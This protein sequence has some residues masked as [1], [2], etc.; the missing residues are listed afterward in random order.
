[1]FAVAV[2]AAHADAADASAAALDRLTKEFPA[3]PLTPAALLQLAELAESRQ[4]W[5]AAAARFT[6][7]AA[8]SEGTDNQAFALRGLAWAHLKQRDFGPAAE[9]FGRIV[10]QFPNHKLASECMYY[11]AESLRE[12]GKLE[13]AVAAYGDVLQRF[14]PLK[15]AA[16]GAEQNPPL[17]YAWLAG[18]QRARTLQQM[19]DVDQADAAYAALL[20]K[21]PRPVELDRILDEWALLNYQAENYAKAD[22][23]FRRLLREV[24][25][26]PLADNARLSLAESDLVSGKLDDAKAAFEGLLASDSSD[27]EVKERSLYQLIVLG[28]DRKRW[29]DVR[30]LA[31]RLRR[32]FPESPY[33]V[34]AQYAD[35][36]AILS[37][38][39]TGETEFAAAK[40]LLDAV[41]QSAGDN[42]AKDAFEARAWVL[43][44]EIAFR[45]KN[46]D[47]AFRLAADFNR[48]HPDS[49]FHYQVEEIV[50]RCYKQQ[51]NFEEARRAFERVL[52]D[53]AAF[54]TSTAAKAQ[55]L[56]GETYF[57]E[58]KWEEAF[59]AYQKVYA[60]YD[61]PEWQA[62]ALLQSGK[63]DERLNQWKD[64]ARTYAQLLHEFPQ[65]EFAKEAQERLEFAKKKAAG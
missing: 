25:G 8:V 65:S 40:K 34:Y 52:S 61:F 62:P 24:P 29:S 42:L 6:A 27:A 35:A 45:E 53:P 3:H 57:L 2:A 39:K 14:A 64:A 41:M 20:E 49:I 32:D 36:E 11:L 55:F 46:Y 26:S 60:S 10:R 47:E 23:L 63:C 30:Q 16:P 31:S 1:L 17:I 9:H 43:A 38:P 33:F 13:Q 28:V 50:G 12:G 22:E 56:I 58:E 18:R 59:L 4:D 48:R 44:A 21:F 5:P 37:S 7:L 51:A 19:K 54:R 15:P